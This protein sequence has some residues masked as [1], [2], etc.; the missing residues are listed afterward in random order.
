MPVEVRDSGLSLRL[1][2]MIGLR[3]IA[4]TFLVAGIDAV[5]LLAAM[6]NENKVLRDAALQRTNHIAS[7]A[8]ASCCATST[9]EIIS[10][11]RVLC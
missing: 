10:W 8:P 4:L 5:R 1:A 9:S 11:I 3:G 2:L 7:I 6:R